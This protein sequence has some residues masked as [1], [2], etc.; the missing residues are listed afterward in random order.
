MSGLSYLIPN[1]FERIGFQRLSCDG[2]NHDDGDGNGNEDE[3]TTMIING[4]IA[5]SIATTV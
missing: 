3:P 2:D 5:A 4:S 1:H